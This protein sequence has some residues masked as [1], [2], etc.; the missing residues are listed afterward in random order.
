MRDWLRRPRRAPRQ[1]A[2]AALSARIDDPL[3]LPDPPAG[4]PQPAAMPASSALP[5]PRAAATRRTIN[6]EV[7]QVARSNPATVATVIRDWTDSKNRGN[8]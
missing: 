1:A 2:P 7:L 8:G 5:A 6:D 4:L 3:Q